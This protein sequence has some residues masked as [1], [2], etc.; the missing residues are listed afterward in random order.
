MFQLFLATPEKRLVSDSE[1]SEI[2]V[3]A[4]AGELN[5]LPGHAPLMTTLDPGVLSYKLKSG[6]KER[7]AIGWG[8]CQVSA[9]GVSVLVEEAVSSGE[10]EASSLDKEIQK[11]EMLLGQEVLS[12]DDWSRTEKMLATYRA[13]LALKSEKH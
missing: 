6:V 13:Q 11:L 8:Y 2:T 1:L 12:E 9:A 4:Y 10:I 5:I 7:L 3:P